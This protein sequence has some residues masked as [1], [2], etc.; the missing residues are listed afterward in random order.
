MSLPTSAALTPLAAITR[1]SPTVVRILGLNPGPFTL[2]GSNIYLV[3]TRVLV[4]TGAGEREFPALISPLLV[5]PTQPPEPLTVIATHSHPDH[6]G[7][8]HQIAEMCRQSGR[9]VR[10]MKRLG[11]DDAEHGLIP[12][13]P[14]QDGD[15]VDG[16]RVVTTPGHTVDHIC[17][18]HEKE[19]LLFSGDCVLGQGTAVFNDLR[20]YLSSLEKLLAQ[21][22][23]LSTI[24]PGHG[25]VIEDGRKR[26]LSYISH[27][28]QREEEVLAQLPATVD[29]M[30]EALYPDVKGAVRDAAKRG[31]LM[32]IKKLEEEGRAELGSD[33]LHYKKEAPPL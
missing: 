24:L 8:V 33:G 5:P 25:P 20:T 27:R 19:Q 4:D 10:F 7:G 18:W 32:H 30:A 3:N 28:R 2:Q 26:I 13:Q 9:P 31:I 29:A 14:L 12:W 23:T 21:F 11:P 16:L 22:P 17:L 1:V 15:I 6:V